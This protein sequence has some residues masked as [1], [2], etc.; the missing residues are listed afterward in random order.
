MC[1]NTKESHEV[2][3]RV[4]SLGERFVGKA[5]LPA[6]IA[7]FLNTTR[8]CS[9]TRNSPAKFRLNGKGPPTSVFPTSWSNARIRT[10]PLSFAPGRDIFR[11]QLIVP[12]GQRCNAGVN[13]GTTPFPW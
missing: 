10:Q 7:V 9:R 8:K 13:H 6:I 4:A 1:G 5:H 11:T 3:S 12:V 2:L